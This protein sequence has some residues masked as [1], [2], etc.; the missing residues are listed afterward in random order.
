MDQKPLIP[1][2]AIIKDP[3]G[4]THV[5]TAVGFT[6]GERYYWLQQSD[7]RAVSVSMLPA[8]VIEEW[9]LVC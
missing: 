3:G 2:G 6:G 8:F 1:I 4:M 5:V 9:E 7:T